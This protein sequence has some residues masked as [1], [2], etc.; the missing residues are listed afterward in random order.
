MRQ[1][2]YPTVHGQQQ[3]KKCSTQ[4]VSRE[5]TVKPQSD[6]I[7]VAEIRQTTLNSSKDLEQQDVCG[8]MKG[9]QG[10]RTIWKIC[11]YSYS[12]FLFRNI[13]QKVSKQNLLKYTT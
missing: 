3:K 9:R 4:V 5:L 8:R 1:K 2:I 12:D 11:V 10:Q 6:A 7:S 13:K